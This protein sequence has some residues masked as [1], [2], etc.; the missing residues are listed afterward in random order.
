LSRGHERRQ[1]PCR[2]GCACRPAGCDPGAAS[3]RQARL[4]RRQVELELGGEFRVGGVVRAEEAELLAD[5]LHAAD[6]R[7]RPAGAAQVHERLRVDREEPDRRAVLGRHVRERRLVREGEVAQPRS[8]VLDELVDDAVLAKHLGHAEHQVGRGRALGERAGELHAHDFGEQHVVG[9]PE[10]HRLGLDAAHAP[11]DHAEAV[12]HGRVRVRA[13]QRIR[14][15]DERAIVLAPVDHR[16][17]VL[18]V[19]LVHDARAGRYHGEVVECFLGPAQER[20][21]LVVP[22]ELLLDVEPERVGE[23][24]EVHLHRVV[25]HEVGGDHRVDARRVA[26]EVLQPVAHGREVHDGRDAGEV[27]EHHPSGHE[28]HVGAG[29]SGAPAGHGEHVVLAHVVAA[30]VS[31]GVLQ[32][33]PDGEREAVERVQDALLDEPGRIVEIGRAFG[34]VDGSAGA[35]RV[36]LWLRHGGSCGRRSCRGLDP[37][38]VA[39]REPCHRVPARAPS[40]PT[41]AA[42]CPDRLPAGS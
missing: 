29:L 22:L 18:E 3:A 19:H 21:P 17:Q 13:H 7:L 24:E 20:V 25:D 37:N 28:G 35:E 9:L 15:R 6:E 42:P 32:E 16:G 30:R 34:E 36:F 4:H 8:V 11:A 23:T 39:T 1:G 5:A 10:H 33:N 14:V 26:A 31:Q 27:L 2:T 40:T 12:H 38:D 41:R